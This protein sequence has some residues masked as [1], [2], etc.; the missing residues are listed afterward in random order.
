MDPKKLAA[1]LGLNPETAT[2]ESLE[3]HPKTAQETLAAQTTQ[4]TELQ[5]KATTLEANLAEANTKVETL[6]AEVTSLKPQAEMGVAHFEAQKAEAL[7]IYGLAVGDKK[8]E[9]MLKLMEEAKDLATLQ[10]FIKTFTEQAEA[11]APLTCQKCGC[12]D[13]GRKASND[14]GHKGTDNQVNMSAFELQRLESTLEV[15]HR[16]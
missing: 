15:M 12:T 4:V 6:S 8:D 2:L 14:T 16:K 13:V 7:R 3:A 11:L 1:L 5:A 10:G 9:S